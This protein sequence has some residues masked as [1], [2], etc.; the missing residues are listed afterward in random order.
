MKFTSEGGITIEAIKQADVVK[1]L[2]HDTG[3][4]IS[5]QNQNLLFRKFQQAGDSLITRDTTKGTGLGLYIS[6]LLVEGMGGKIAL[7]KSEVGKGTTFSFTLP[8]SKDV[9][10][11][12][13]LPNVDILT[14]AEM[15]TLP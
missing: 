13:P 9:Q 12:T 5:P 7:E 4:G 15:V 2:V 6:K 1:V 8:V 3:R 10:E 11:I 14:H